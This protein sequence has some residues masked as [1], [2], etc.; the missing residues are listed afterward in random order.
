MSQSPDTTILEQPLSV[1]GY[2]VLLPVIELEVTQRL[3]PLAGAIARHQGGRV[4]IVRVV[5]VPD[6]QPLSDGV[7][8]ARPEGGELF[9]P[10]VQLI[11]DVV[12]DD[13]PARRA[14]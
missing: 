11:R 7:L 14:V 3:L 10:S 13:Y 2:L 5:V 4:L 1:N 6:D 8:E 9:G 12:V